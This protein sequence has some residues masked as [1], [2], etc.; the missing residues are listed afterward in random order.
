VI[1]EAEYSLMELKFFFTDA[2]SKD[3]SQILVA[4]DDLTIVSILKSV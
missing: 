2:T 3:F 1:F 4:I